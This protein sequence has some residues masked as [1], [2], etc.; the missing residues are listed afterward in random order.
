MTFKV[1]V[2]QGEDG[3]SVASCPSLKSCSSQGNS[4]EE[5][6]ADIREAIALYL[7]APRPS[8]CAAS[9]GR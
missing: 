2:K 8:I 7:E 5:A 3:Y 6:L 9:N 1:V 4:T